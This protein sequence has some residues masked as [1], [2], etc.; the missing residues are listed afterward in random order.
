[1][2]VHTFCA[3]PTEKSR[4]GDAVEPFGLKRRAGGVRSLSWNAPFPR[5]MYA[6][7]RKLRRG[8]AKARGGPTFAPRMDKIAGRLHS[9]IAHLGLRRRRL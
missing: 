4:W 3:R 5:I 8:P 6:V 2:L 1:M 7:A 9:A